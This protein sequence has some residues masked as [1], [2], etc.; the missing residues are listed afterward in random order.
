MSF[1][2]LIDWSSFWS[3]NSLIFH[4][5]EAF[6]CCF[7]KPGGMG[8]RPARFGA[9]VVRQG[10][11]KS[12]FLDVCCKL[13]NTG[14]RKQTTHDRCGKA[15]IRCH[16]APWMAQRCSTLSNLQGFRV[17]CFHTFLQRGDQRAE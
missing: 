13:G 10:Y 14:M 11:T 6:F 2:G 15:K 5:I 17:V 9:L 1:I 4:S 8:S 3:G 7:N 12:V 16:T